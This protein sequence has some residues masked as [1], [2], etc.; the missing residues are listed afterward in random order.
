MT[1]AGPFRIQKLDIIDFYSKEYLGIKGK[2]LDGKSLFVYGTNN[3][4]KST[5]FDAIIYAIFGR[6]FVDRPISMANTKIALSNGEITIEIERKYNSEPK[7]KIGKEEIKGSQQ[8]NEKIIELFK[9]PKRIY[10]AK[11]LIN[12]LILPQKDEDTL[13]RKY[14]QNQLNYIL[15]SFSSGTDTSLRIEDIESEIEKLQSLLERFEFEKRDALIEIINLKLIQQK[16]KNYYYD[17]KQFLEQY[18]SR[19]I[20]KTIEIL[21]KNGEIK[22]K[23]G[24]LFSKRT[25]KYNELFKTGNELNRLRQYY[26][27]ELIEIIKQTLAVLVCP[28]CGDN[29]DLNKV[30]GRKDRNICPFCGRD[31]YTGELYERL[32]QEISIS[33]AKLSEVL[34]TESILKLDIKYIDEKIK[35]INKEKLGIEI[36]PVIFRIIKEMKKQSE[37]EHTYEDY[38]LLLDKYIQE[39][40]ESKEKIE[41]FNECVDRIEI[42]I[43]TI[44]ENVEKLKEE[45][46]QII[47]DE[48]LKGIYEFNDQLNEIFT[49]LVAPLPY[50]LNIQNDSIILNTEIVQKNCLDKHAL[51]FS[52]KKLVD[53]ALWATFQKINMKNNILNIN[54]GLLDDIFE[55]IDNNEFKWKTNLYL[56]IKDVEK[57]IQLILFS[58]DKQMNN[59][60]ELPNE[61]NLHLQL[62]FDSFQRNN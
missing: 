28:I 41:G 22:Q 12:A 6:E 16:N 49:K 30:D 9:I 19:E 59:Y 60:L 61:Q 29:L 58:I 21:E 34:E 8:V 7:L 54:F 32:N 35:E 39:L 62:N 11:M 37:L 14:S 18:E 36:N 31:H 25:E 38:K 13:L 17:I 53:F 24:E 3:T 48:N 2:N 5:S 20:E 15:M 45:R 10:N 57:N 42:K 23:I 43:K 56:I 1:G 51:G 46:R 47:E 26:N 33:N 4:G 44:L 27:K 40:D 50:K 55:N 52:Q